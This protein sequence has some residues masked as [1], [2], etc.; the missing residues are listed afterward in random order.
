[1]SA[2]WILYQELAFLFWALEVL[3]ASSLHNPHFLNVI[4]DFPDNLRS[5]G[6][7][8]DETVLSFC[9][10]W[11]V[12]ML[13][14]VAKLLTPIDF[15][16]PTSEPVNFEILLD[17]HGRT[18]LF[19][20]QFHYCKLRFFWDIFF[21]FSIFKVVKFDLILNLLLLLLFLLGKYYSRSY[22]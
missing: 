19:L 6:N 3:S 16:P 4:F 8:L 10:I 5:R 14:L 1:M 22:Q 17:W 9:E 20:Y 15:I 7:Y 13:E 18:W 11:S 21:V 12:A 2:L